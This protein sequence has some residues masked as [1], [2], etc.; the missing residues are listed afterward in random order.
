MRHLFCAGVAQVAKPRQRQVANP[1][2]KIRKAP[3]DSVLFG[4]GL[5]ET[6]TE[7]LLFSY[8]NINGK[9]YRLKLNEKEQSYSIKVWLFL[10]FYD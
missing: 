9:I 10:I 3:I 2:A 8:E 4:G 6:P 5:D 1:T 7:H